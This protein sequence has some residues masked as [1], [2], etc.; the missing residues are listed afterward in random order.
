MC[1]LGGQLKGME[2]VIIGRRCLHALQRR[3][4]DKC[5]SAVRRQFACIADRRTEL[6]RERTKRM[7]KMAC[8][9]THAR[10]LRTPV[11]GDTLRLS[12][13]GH[14]GQHDLTVRTQQVIHKNCPIIPSFFSN[15][16]H[17]RLTRCCYSPSVTFFLP[18]RAERTRG[19]PDI[20][21]YST[22]TAANQI[23]AALCDYGS[24]GCWTGSCWL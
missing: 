5:A 19:S 4:R 8:G 10:V 23:T 20:I 16:P 9:H 21:N 3:G 1:K 15:D 22:F 18:T 7:H 11:R 6:K 14:L 12:G 2:H 17:R 13:F 24:T